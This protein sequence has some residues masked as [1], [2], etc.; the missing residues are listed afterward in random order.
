MNWFIGSSPVVTTNNY[1][2]IDDLH[3]LQSLHINLLTLF[4]L[5]FTI[6]FLA[7]IYNTFTVNKS[8]KHTLILLLIYDDTVLQFNLKSG[9]NPSYRLSL[10]RHSTDHAESTDLLLRNLTTGH[11]EPSSHFCLL[12]CLQNCYLATS[13]NIRYK[14]DSPL[15]SCNTRRRYL[16]RCCLA[17]RW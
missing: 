5:V 16:P 12:D 11:R 15:L 7:R 3:N 4:P 17:M 1:Y 8:S 14:M 13:C 9:L 6:R 2:T 10:Y